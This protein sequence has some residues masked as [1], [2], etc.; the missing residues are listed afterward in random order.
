M[1]SMKSSAAFGRA[2]PFFLIA[3]L[4]VLTAQT[5]ITSSSGPQIRPTSTMPLDFGRVVIGGVY[6]KEFTTEVRHPPVQIVKF[7]LALERPAALSV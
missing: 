5:P 4:F 7:R 6:H 2:N 1:P 3:A